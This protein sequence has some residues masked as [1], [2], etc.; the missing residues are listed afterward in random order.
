MVPSRI[1]C[2]ELRSPRVLSMGVRDVY[3]D[4]L[5]AIVDTDDYAEVVTWHQTSSDAG[6]AI[7]VILFQTDQ[8]YFSGSN[9]RA[10]VQMGEC[11]V[12]ASDV[13]TP[14]LDH[15]FTDGDGERWEVES[16]RNRELGGT[17]MTVSK[18]IQIERSR[19]DLRSN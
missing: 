8:S 5:G 12:K 3:E 14:L 11:F 9:G 6:V 10:M 13:A 17:L 4:D 15:W 16:I 18:R 7:T 1:N 19:G 2:S